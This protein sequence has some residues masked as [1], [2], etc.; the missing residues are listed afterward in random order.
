MPKRS[1]ADM[2]VPPLPPRTFD[3]AFSEHRLTPDER[4]AMVWHLAAIRMRR[5]IEELAPEPTPD[6]R[7]LRDNKRETP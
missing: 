4:T 2:A 5:L 3:V 6:M 1:R 7:V